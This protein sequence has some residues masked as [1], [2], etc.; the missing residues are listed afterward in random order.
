MYFHPRINEISVEELEAADEAAVDYEEDDENYYWQLESEFELTGLWGLNIILDVVGEDIVLE[1][2]WRQVCVIRKMLVM[3]ILRSLDIE[4][5]MEIN[6]EEG[7]AAMVLV[8]DIIEG[9]SD[10][11]SSVD[12]ERG[13]LKTSERRPSS[14]QQEC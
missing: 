5:E 1:D 13:P 14:A 10:D 2:T 4:S 12:T 3:D 8:R 7:H 11:L 6:S 9:K